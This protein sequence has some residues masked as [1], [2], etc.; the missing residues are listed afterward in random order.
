MIRG[1]ILNSRA[2]RAR[3]SG[4][5]IR[6]MVAVV[7]ALAVTLAA[8]A[9]PALAEQRAGGPAASQARPATGPHPA[10]GRMSSGAPW[11]HI[12][13]GEYY[14]CGIRTGGTLWCWGDNGNGQLG[15]GNHTDHDRPQQVTG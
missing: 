9:A 10:D 8:A 5:A 3:R 2:R 11:A 4:P 12:A 1:G 7:A 14:L 13:A 6:V 15:L